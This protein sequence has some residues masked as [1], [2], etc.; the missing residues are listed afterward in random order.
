V[1]VCGFR[2]GVC[3]RCLG[4]ALVVAAGQARCPG[5]KRMWRADAVE[6]CRSPATGT[7]L[8]HRAEVPEVVAACE[9]HAVAVGRASRRARITVEEVPRPSRSPWSFLIFGAVALPSANLVGR[10][11]TARDA[12]E[13]SA[14][15]V[16]LAM[17]W[18]LV[19]M[20]YGAAR[21]VRRVRDRRYEREVRRLEESSK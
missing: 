5:C 11:I 6:P 3:D 14:V 8:A 7:A 18:G 20:L 9:S 2:W 21:I 10:L 16:G 12:G 1:T 17:F 19:S 15:A 4:T 13:R